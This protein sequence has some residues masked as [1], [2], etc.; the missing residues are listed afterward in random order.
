MYPEATS[1]TWLFPQKKAAFTTDRNDTLTLVLLHG[2]LAAAVFIP[3]IALSSP[4]GCRFPVIVTV[5]E[6]H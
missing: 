1:A 2:Q 5:E 4:I 3:G 6:M